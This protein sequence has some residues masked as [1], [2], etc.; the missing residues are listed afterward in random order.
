MK[1]HARKSTKRTGV[2]SKHISMHCHK[3]LTLLGVEG[4]GVQLTLP[5]RTHA[6]RSRDTSLHRHERLTL[7]GVSALVK[8]PEIAVVVLIEG[9]GVLFL[10]PRRIHAVRSRKAAT[11]SHS[12]ISKIVDPK[13]RP[14]GDALRNLIFQRAFNIRKN[15]HLLVIRWVPNHSKVPENKKA[16]VIAKEVA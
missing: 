2:R 7:L 10:L 9:P 13:V 14:G 12:A 8:G 3:G 15:G 16:D 4:P 11:G 5:Q 6:V 1:T